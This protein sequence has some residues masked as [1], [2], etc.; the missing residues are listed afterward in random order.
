MIVAHHFSVHGSFHFAVD[1]I[2]LNRLYQQFILMGGCLGNVTFVMISGY[3][4][5]N[6]EHI[7]LRRLFNLW[8]RMF[9]YSVIIYSLFL[10][11]GMMAFDIKTMLKVF[12]PIA[13]TQWWFAST[14]FVMY[15]IHPYINIMLHSFTREDYKKFLTAIFLYWCIIP[16]LTKSNFQSNN[17][18]NFI[19]LYS[20]AGYIRLWADDYGNKKFIWYGIGFIALNFMTVIALN[21]IG[22]MIPFFGGKSGFFCG[23]M[24]PFTI[25]ACLCLL[26]GFKHLDIQ[27]SRIINTIAFAAFGVY[28][29][30]D[31]NFVRPFLWID[32][33]K[34]ALFQNSPYLIPYSI[35]VI[36]F[37]YASCTLIELM[38]SK[39][40]RVISR[41][42]LS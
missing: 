2:T 5:V 1:S 34:N 19:S 30:H 14:Y 7:K 38:R 8:V 33:F 37:V 25:L 27:N 31:N 15:L 28:L 17:L 42:R 3:F 41:G 39:I 21:L 4:L 23:M 11:S 18:I 6:S 12:M 24:K 36:V 29:I 32:L 40:F 22:L 13:R 16:V 26:I 9:F 35:A 10:L 20:L